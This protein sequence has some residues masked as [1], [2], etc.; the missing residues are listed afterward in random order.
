VQTY[1]PTKIRNVA[2]V[3]HGGAGKTSLAEALL[4]VSGAT[5]RQGRVEDGTTVADTDPEEIKRRISVSL[6]VTPFEWPPSAGADGHKINLIDCPGYADFANEVVAALSVADLAVFVVSAVEGVEIETR[7]AWR[8]AQ[9]RRL[10]R[11]IF[12]N[13]LDRERADFGRTLDQLREIFGAGVAPLELPIG[14][15]AAF[16][17]VADLLTDTA[18]I[19]ADGVASTG[20]IPDDIAPAEHEIHDALIEGIVVADDDLMERY[21]E[22]D[23]PSTLELERTMARG[24][25]D[26]TVFPV[27]C[28][29]ATKRIAIDRLANFI[30]EIGPAPTDR[31]P[32]VVRGGGA[33]H[34]VSCDPAGEALAVVFKT[35]ADP[36]VGKVSLFKVLSGTVRPN[37]VLTNPRSHHDER[38]HALF[39][40]RGKEHIDV[41]VVG[42]GD[43]AAVAKLA[44]TSTGDTL[45]PKHTPV[46]VT[47][48]EILDPVLAIAIRPRSK[49]D[50]D[51]LMTA[52]HRL[53]EEDTAVRVQ[54]NDETRQTLLSG[55]GETH[56]AVVL[57]RLARKF[58]VGVE[59]EPVRVPYRETITSPAEAE[60]RYKKQTGGHGQYGVASIRVHPADRGA[61]F[62]F[63]DQIVGGAIP[64]QFIPAVEKGIAEAMVQ[65]GHYGFPVVDVTV[66]CFDGKYHPVDSSEMSFRMAGALA[67]HEAL[68]KATPV[69]LE[70]ISTL[71]VVVPS[72]HQGDVLGDLNARRGRVFG[73]DTRPDG[74]QSVQ[75]LVPTAELARYAV[76]LRSLTGGAGRFVA[77]HDHY[78]LLP[79]HLYDKV[80]VADQAKVGV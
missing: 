44:A 62:G 57:E 32:V 69:I 55:M 45:A 10:P 72:A 73:T 36:Y 3:G 74:E 80:V 31:P 5:S 22:G 4:F 53:Q 60:G 71:E 52:L 23:V 30:C 40:V 8:M 15:E 75:A 2:L 9:A 26:A 29:S 17:G 1:P 7:A 27:V 78:D 54:R 49:G 46:T 66:T 51:K 56:L 12:V 20:P 13:K 6:A 37:D 24:V 70:P 41:G 34:P 63:V 14:D 50:D 65:G 33:E 42:A 43:I 11:M 21:L 47:A 48:L 64:R 58:G 77:S 35:V 39:A 16:G 25:A 68:A 76:D 79:L 67:L 18:I 19:Y 38:L 28:G 61:G 59:T